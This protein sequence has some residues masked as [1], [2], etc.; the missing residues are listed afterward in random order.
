MHEA[1]ARRVKQFTQKELAGRFG[2]SLSTVFNALNIPRKI[3]A[4]EVTGRFFRLR[5]PEKLLYLWATHRNLKKDILYA[6]HCD[7]SATQIESSMPGGVVFGAFSAYRLAHKD[8]PADYGVIY[9]YTDDLETIKK[10]FPPAKGYQNLFV[11]KPDPYL[12][13]FGEMTPDAQT[14]VD[15]WNIPEW[16]AKDFLDALKSVMRL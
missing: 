2:F 6:T 5:D 12:A 15:L 3:G 7:L 1:L 11:L 10:R 9:I 8:A 14:F 13:S 4:I 16:Y